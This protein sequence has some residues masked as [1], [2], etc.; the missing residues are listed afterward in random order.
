MTVWG[1]EH[2]MID[3]QRSLNDAGE[4]LMTLYYESLDGVAREAVEMFGRERV[5]T[6]RGERNHETIVL[7][8]ELVFGSVSIN[9]EIGAGKIEVVIRKVRT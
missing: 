6:R 5:M 9:A 2:G 8:D 1:D 3:I 4:R 7:V